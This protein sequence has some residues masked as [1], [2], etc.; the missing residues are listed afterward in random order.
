MRRLIMLVAVLLVTWL[1]LVTLTTWD[2]QP[3]EPGP[4]TSYAARS[5]T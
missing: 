4:P 2:S 5:S 3:V 1:A